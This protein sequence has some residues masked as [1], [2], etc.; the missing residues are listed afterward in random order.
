MQTVIDLLLIILL[1]AVPATFGFFL[2]YCLGHPMS[3]DKVSVKE[4]FFPYS[5]MLAKRRLRQMKLLK[6]INNNFNSLMNSDDPGTRKEGIKQLNLT[7]MIEGRK[8]FTFEQA[9]GMCPF[10]TNF[11]LSMIAATFF[12][13]LIPL[14]FFNPF[15]FFIFIPIFSHTILRK[16]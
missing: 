3:E 1:A 15:V 13:F 10:C 5:L 12:F 7:I 8:Y 6:G 9:I 11:W 16:L 14:S 2:D 4:I